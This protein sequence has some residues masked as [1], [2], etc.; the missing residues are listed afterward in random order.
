MFN[1]NF[2]NLFA[3][4][5]PFP[6]RDGKSITYV[7]GGKLSFTNINWS[8]TACTFERA[9]VSTNYTAN[10]VVFG[11]S[12]QPATE[13][14]YKLA[15]NIITNISWSTT[16][17]ISSEAITKICTI[18]NNNDTE[19]TIKEAAYMASFYCYNSSWG[20]SSSS[21]VIDRAVLDTPVTIPAGGIGQVEY[22]IT[23]NL[24]TA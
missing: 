1:N 19:I 17:K 20:N 2:K 3:A 22:T 21:C 8:G 10:T 11:D 9:G 23:F 13:G 15:G 4:C 6:I 24:P 5:A 12:D 7:G 18:T 16:T 14:D